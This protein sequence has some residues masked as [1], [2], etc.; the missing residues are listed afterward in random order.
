MK[1]MPAAVCTLVMIALLHLTPQVQGQTLE[2]G[3]RLEPFMDHF[4]IKE[5]DN[6][7][8]RL[9]RPVP[10][11]LVLHN[12]PGYLP[13]YNG[14]S[15]IHDGPVY[16]LYYSAANRLGVLESHNGRDWFRPAVGLLTGNTPDTNLVKTTTSEL[17]IPADEPL[18][19]VFL[20][21]R[22]DIPANQRYKAFTLDE[23]GSTKVHCWVSGNG[24]IWEKYQDEPIIE[25]RLYGAFDGFESMFWSGS[26]NCYVLYI[27]YYLRGETTEEGRRS[28][29]RMTS[30]DFKTWS[31]PRPMTFGDD[32]LTPPEHHYQNQTSPYFRAPHIY[33][34]LSSRFMQGRSAFDAE[35]ERA[36]Q[37][38]L[39][40][41][42][43]QIEDWLT[44][45]ISETV[46]M[47]TRGG[48]HYDR[49]FMEGFVRPGLGDENWTT[50]SNYALRGIVPTGPGEM[51]LYVSRHNALPSVHIRRYTLRLDGIGSVHASYRTG[52]MVT[53]PVTFNGTRLV[54]NYST[55]AAGS[56]RVGLLNQDGLPI[57]G[58]DTNRCIPLI[59]DHLKQVVHWR[60][61]TDLSSLQS[62]PLRLV[63][64]MQDADLYSLQF[65]P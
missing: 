31:Q 32:G 48:T 16:L 9:H 54:I 27:R 30:P 57:P 41:D 4:L 37:L 21:T 22:P 53:H 36:R 5:M 23:R 35:P 8:L 65:T 20:D 49:A 17:M 47:T 44:S 46:V 14:M 40:R 25:T 1:T 43:Q 11:N 18:P 34:A 64:E 60:D 7:A 59:G 52:R 10:A 51:S 62:Q 15:V 19:E 33:V 42:S 3:S 26:E 6:T 50:R 55:S 13:L 56:I 38:K 58:F 24:K 61:A 2:I 28:I 12:Q 39:A 29:A 63:F 45:D